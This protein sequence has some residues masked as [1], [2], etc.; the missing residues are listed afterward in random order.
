MR[1][2]SLLRKLL[3]AEYFLCSFTRSGCWGRFIFDKEY[4]VGQ[5]VV[6]TSFSIFNAL[7]T[8][9]E[10]TERESAWTTVRVFLGDLVKPEVEG[11]DVLEYND[12]TKLFDG[13]DFCERLSDKVE[14]L[15]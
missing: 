10:A 9:P 4:D 3:K 12:G 5:L 1:L 6:V 2:F 8:K 13:T 14:T 7:L 15:V 11:D